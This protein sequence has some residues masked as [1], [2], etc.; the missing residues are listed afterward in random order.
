[1]IYDTYKA[2]LIESDDGSFRYKVEDFGGEGIS[3]QSYFY[4]QTKCE[5][6]INGIDLDA[7]ILIGNALIEVA[8]HAKRRED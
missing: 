1:M 7:A 6:E 8:R 2:T 5:D 3:I 4:G